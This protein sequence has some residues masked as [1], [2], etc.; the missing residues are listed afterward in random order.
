VIAA[1]RDHGLQSAARQ[2][3]SVALAALP[4]TERLIAE[5]LWMA[6]KKV[7]VPSLADE[8]GMTSAEV[9]KTG[10]QAMKN[11]RAILKDYEEMA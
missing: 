11:L 1:T 4:E 6:P 3:V 9:R 5:A 8:L 2:D 7:S 10:K